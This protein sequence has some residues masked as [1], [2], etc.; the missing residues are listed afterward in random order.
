MVFLSCVIGI[1]SGPRPRRRLKQSAAVLNRSSG[2]RRIIFMHCGGLQSLKR[3]A[4]RS[5]MTDIVAAAYQSAGLSV[6]LVYF[7]QPSMCLA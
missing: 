1:G 4:S 5:Q 7:L 6:T 3:L 2:L